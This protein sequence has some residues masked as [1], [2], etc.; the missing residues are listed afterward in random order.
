MKF[1][2]SQTELGQFIA[3]S[4]T[5]NEDLHEDIK[6]TNKLKSYF[7]NKTNI[8]FFF[9]FYY[10]P[11]TTGV[12]DYSRAVPDMEQFVPRVELN[13]SSSLAE[14]EPNEENLAIN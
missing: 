11:N 4:A 8:F 12:Y 1:P 13:P 10:F 2:S 3:V 7:V 5:R 9:F 6:L 14:G